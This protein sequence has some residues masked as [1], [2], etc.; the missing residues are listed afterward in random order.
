M[1]VRIWRQSPDS[2]FRWET[3][4]AKYLSGALS[5]LR[6]SFIVNETAC[7]VIGLA[8]TDKGSR[9]FED[10]MKLVMQNGVSVIAVDMAN[11]IVVGVAVN[12]IQ[13]RH[14]SDP[15]SCH[16]FHGPTIKLF[17]LNS[18][19]LSPQANY[20]DCSTAAGWLILVPTF[21]DRGMSRGQ[22]E[23]VPTAVNLGFLDRTDFFFLS[24]SSSVIVTRL[25]GPRPRPTATQRIW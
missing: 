11:D 20:T 16:I 25:N 14:L 19:T 4:S 5:V 17:P 13:V 12:R 15:H 23:G 7:K 10:L 6:T 2:G 22:R 3:L 9:Q 8:Q 21:E 18:V 1:P 24:S